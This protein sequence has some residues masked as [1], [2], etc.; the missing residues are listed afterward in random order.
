MKSTV[1]APENCI[2]CGNCTSVCP[3]GAI[4]FHGIYPSVISIDVNDSISNQLLFTN[5][6]E[7]SNEKEIVEER[8][9]K[10]II[11]KAKYSFYTHE[12]NYFMKREVKIILNTTE[13][14]K[15]QFIGVVG[16]DDTIDNDIKFLST[17]SLLLNQ[18]NIQYEWIDDG[19]PSQN[20]HC[21][22][23]VYKKMK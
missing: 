1:V 15:Q 20:I 17:V 13:G 14:K 21:A 19:I 9:L 2:G 16:N 10:Q 6:A 12:S 5:S 3:V 23:L 8:I 11:E 22:L 7:Q 18:A 4:Q